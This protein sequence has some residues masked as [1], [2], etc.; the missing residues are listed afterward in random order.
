MAPGALERYPICFGVIQADPRLRGEGQVE[1]LV[2][3]KV[4]WFLNVQ[5]PFGR[6]GE[7]IGIE[8]IA[9]GDRLG[10]GL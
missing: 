8:V 2:F 4:L 3:W 6:M 9:D 1:T 10:S 5:C 7:Q